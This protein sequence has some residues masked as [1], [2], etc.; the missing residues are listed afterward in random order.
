MQRAV[1]DCRTRE[2][3]DRC[4]D[5]GSSGPAR[6]RT[7]PGSRRSC[8]SSPGPVRRT[9]PSSWP[10]QP[11]GRFGCGRGSSVEATL[12]TVLPLITSGVTSPLITR[13]DRPARANR[14]ACP[15]PGWAGRRQPRGLLRGRDRGRLVGGRN[16]VRGAGEHQTK[17][18]RPVSR[19][20]IPRAVCALRTSDVMR[21]A[22]SDAGAGPRKVRSMCGRCE[23]PY[24]T[25]N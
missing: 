18:G 25:R 22:G 13:C 24:A 1:E 2:C 4:P 6:Y 19:P 15:R 20:S 5:R 17:A 23:Q 3:S 9:G 7:R 14:G 21:P 10:A 16:R 12:T 11:S 8:R